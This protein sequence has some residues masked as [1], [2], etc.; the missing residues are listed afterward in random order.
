[1]YIY[2]YIYMCVYIHTYIYIDMYTYIHLYI[3]SMDPSDFW[4]QT[5][6]SVGINYSSHTISESCYTSHPISD[7]CH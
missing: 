3:S 1:M 4:C 5:A 2:V 7:R 6:S